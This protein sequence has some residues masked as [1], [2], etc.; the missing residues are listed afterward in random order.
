MSNFILT[1]SKGFIGSALERALLSKDH[2]VNDSTLK[3]DYYLFFGSPSS[4]ILFNERPAECINGTI[5]PFLQACHFC[6]TNHVK[7][8]FPSSATVY[9]NNNR[10]SHTK[11]ALEEIVK[12]YEIPYAAA[13]IFAGYGK[14]EK[15][16]KDYASVVYQFIQMIKK[17]ISPTI[18]GNGKQSRDFV[19]IDD[20]VT[21]ILDRLDYNGVYDIGT[22]VNTTFNHLITIINEKLGTHIYPTYIDTPRGYIEETKCKQPLEKFITIEEGIQRIIN[23]T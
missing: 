16:K 13:R 17:G 4:Q 7:L 11:S 22:G 1:G 20:V 2:T 6:R 10:Y 15:H 5:E 9:D 19:Y 18:Y 21:T 12:A 23:A 3:P 14:G 8:I